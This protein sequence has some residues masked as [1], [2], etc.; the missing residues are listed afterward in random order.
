MRRLGLE[1]FVLAYLLR[2]GAQG[3]T[4]EELE[5]AVEAAARRG[6]LVVADGRRLRVELESYLDYLRAI[7]AVEERNGRLVLRESRIS[8][9]LRRVLEEAAE[10][11]DGVAAQPGGSLVEAT[12]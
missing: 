1:A 12:A 8:P 6:I 5:R 4:V 7:R 9:P 3:A 2:R 11:V 10:L